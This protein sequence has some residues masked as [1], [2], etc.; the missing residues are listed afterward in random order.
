[1]DV[2]LDVHF[3]PRE[4]SSGSD[5]Q[6]EQNELV[7]ARGWWWLQHGLILVGVEVG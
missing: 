2:T 3:Q 7:S 4:T 6:E 5:D 1:M